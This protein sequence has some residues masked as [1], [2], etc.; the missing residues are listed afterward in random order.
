[1]LEALA[2]PFIQRALIAGLLVGSLASYLGVFVVQRRLSFLGD[3]LAHAAFAGFALGLLLHRQPLLVAIP[4]A[5]VVALG[6]T[7]VR[8]KSNLGDDTAIG[9][10]FALSVA[11]GVLFM[12]LR[13]GYTADLSAYMFGS[14][15]AVSSADL[16]ASALVAA[17][18]LALLPMWSR[19][20]YA[21]FDRELALA[22]HKPVLQ[23][24]Y[25]LS[26]LIAVVTVTSVKLVGIVLIAAFLVIPAATSRLLSPTFARM[27]TNA[28]LIGLFSVLIG[29]A[30]S[31]TLDIP[32][33]AT[34]VLCQVTLFTLALLLR[35]R[36]R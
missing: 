36:V 12:S 1:M 2:L 24:D 17:V 25:L 11:L 29:M 9:I 19:W 23:N 13:Q 20:A 21:T 6:V 31:Y 15:L 10:F 34:I 26:A 18:V 33:G 28:V 35:P 16:W 8:E 4:F 7:W 32:S 30:V 5:V 14:I 27:T 3:G 22:D